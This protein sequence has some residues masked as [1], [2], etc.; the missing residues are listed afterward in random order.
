MTKTIKGAKEKKER[1]RRGAVL[2][3]PL[4]KELVDSSGRA[5]QTYWDLY[6]SGETDKFNSRGFGT[7]AVGPKETLPLYLHETLARI[8]PGQREELYARANVKLR[9]GI[10]QCS[11]IPPKGIQK[12]REIVEGT[13][14]QQFE[15]LRTAIEAT[16][17]PNGFKLGLLAGW[18]LGVFFGAIYRHETVR[19]KPERRGRPRTTAL[20]KPVIRSWRR[21]HPEGTWE[22]FERDLREESPNLHGILKRCHLEI[23]ALPQEDDEELFVHGHGLEGVVMVPLLSLKSAFRHPAR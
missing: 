16:P 10:S 11:N 23:D 15:A 4:N 3:G 9:E 6:L 7:E 17:G 21:Q 2:Q 19:R 5:P 20:M 12:L 13:E 1:E 14:E 22:D 8:T 18:V